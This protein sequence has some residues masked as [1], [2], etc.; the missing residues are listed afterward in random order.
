MAMKDKGSYSGKNNRSVSVTEENIR[1]SSGRF[2]P[3]NKAAVGRP[4]G[5]PNLAT[6]DLRELAQQYTEEA[7]DKLVSIMRE[8]KDPNV[9]LKAIGMLL[10]RAHGKPKEFRDVDLTLNN[11]ESFIDE[12]YDEIED[13][14]TGGHQPPSGKLH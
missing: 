14:F 2:L 10:D 8:A 12:T 9:Q 11:H 4:K 3:G 1:D 6:Q 5:K 13:A 7:L